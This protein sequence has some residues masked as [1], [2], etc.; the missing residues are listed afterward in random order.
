[1]SLSLNQPAPD[2][3]LFNTEKQPISLSSFRGQKVV[4][5]F[6]PGAFSGGCTKELCA[7]RDDMASYNQLNAK[8]I[9]ISTDSVFTIAKFKSDQG[10]EFELLSDYNKEVCGQYGAQYDEFLFGMKGTAKRSAFVID[11]NGMVIYAQVND[12]P[13]DMPDFDAVKAALA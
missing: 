6:Y 3:T 8:V 4:L 13:G 1:M 7:I 9:G 12:S 2:F 5:Y 10:Y 11:E